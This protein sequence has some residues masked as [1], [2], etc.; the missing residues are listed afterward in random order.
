MVDAAADVVTLVRVIKGDDQSPLANFSAGVLKLA[1]AKPT[2]SGL[3]EIPLPP[4]LRKWHSV[5][6]PK[7]QGRAT[8]T[9]TRMICDAVPRAQR[10]AGST[11]N[12]PIIVAAAS[13]S[14]APMLSHD[15]SL[16]HGQLHGVKYSSE[17]LSEA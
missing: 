8:D 10:V 13:I 11:L 4:L 16:C 14:L 2:V 7:P 9:V 5:S 6:R 12:L 17:P 3:L 15:P 1:V